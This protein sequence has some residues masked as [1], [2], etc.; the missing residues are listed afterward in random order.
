MDSSKNKEDEPI[1]IK[2]EIDLGEDFINSPKK[3]PIK[4]ET[5]EEFNPFSSIKTEDTN[6]PTIL[7]TWIKQEFPKDVQIFPENL[8]KIGA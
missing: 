2:T 4:T 1:I 8:N 7:K 3:E 6:S 5:D